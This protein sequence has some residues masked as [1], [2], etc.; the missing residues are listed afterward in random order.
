MKF[1][2]HFCGL[3][4]V[5]AL[6]LLAA[7]AAAQDVEYI[8]AV[9]RAQEQRP[10]A[11]ANSARIAPATEPG[12]PM[13]LQG[14][15]VKPDGTP[16]VGTIV[17][18]YQTDRTGLYD[19]PEAGAHSWRLKGW[20]KADEAGRFTFETIRPAPYPGRRVPA[21][22]HFTLFTPSGE[23][24]HAGEAKFEDDEL[25]SAH[26]RETSRQA[27]DFGEVRPVRRE[28]GKEH[29]EVTL[30]IDPTQRF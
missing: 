4:I 13:V 7:R 20:A 1:S 11:I 14:R 8:R 22:V 21:H 26:Q 6:Q 29:V 9:E 18:A 15:V 12:T 28:A 5:A 25:V 10:K 23:R 19:R 17:F 24:Y 2:L 27:G 3:T 16:A 30:R